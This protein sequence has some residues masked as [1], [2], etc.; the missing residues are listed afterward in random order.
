M[1]ADR[2]AR[3]AVGPLFA[4]LLQRQGNAAAVAKFKEQLLSTSEMINAT[5]ILKSF[6]K[7]PGSG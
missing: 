3:I 5:L 6:L 4:S 7:S 1:V 2:H